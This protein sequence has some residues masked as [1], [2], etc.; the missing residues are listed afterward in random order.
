MAARTASLGT[1]CRELYPTGGE[2]TVVSERIKEAGG[3][4]NQLDTRW[5][6]HQ[7]EHCGW[8]AEI[9]KWAQGTVEFT[10]IAGGG[11][12]NGRQLRMRRDV[13]LCNYKLAC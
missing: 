1:L 9:S 5:I 12:N 11:S 7:R 6:C 10:V 4:E 2:R 13:F 3:E 8:V